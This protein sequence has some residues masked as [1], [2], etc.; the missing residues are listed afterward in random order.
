MVDIKKI[1]E[2]SF[3]LLNKQR[4]LIIPF[5]LA[6]AI[7]LA[8]IFLFVQF[9]GLSPLLRELA[10]AEGEF[11]EQKVDY[12]LDKE[13]LRDE[14]YTFEL[15]GYLG[16]DRANSPY[17]DQFSDYLAEKGFDYSGFIPLFN[18]KNGIMLGIFILLGI[19]G[20]IYF[21]VMSYT[22]ISPA[23]AKKKAM[24]A[25]EAANKLV[26]RFI[27]VRIL[28]AIIFIA[29]L[30]ILG[31]AAYL[32]GSFAAFAVFMA[33]IVLYMAY[34]IFAGIKLLFTL[35]I[36]FIE[37]RGA[38]AS[39]KQSFTSTKGRFKQVFFI[40]FVIWGIGIFINSFVAQPL[41]DIFYNFIFGPNFLKIFAN[42]IFLLLFLALES[43]VM[44]FQRIF[45]FNAYLD[46]KANLKNQQGGK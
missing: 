1:F 19:V 12:L 16:K 39:L 9:S 31:I 22:V 8:L 32:W 33:L 2:D 45:L 26:F 40:G 14:N 15:L 43:I 20:T 6:T 30:I 23:T 27:L 42:F 3:N 5:F 4:K 29:P 35:P 7:P 13:N 10:A 28:L 41:Y 18:A 36:M 44:T 17:H 25:A 34:L 11:Q 24:N 38:F 37:D 21:S 46:Y